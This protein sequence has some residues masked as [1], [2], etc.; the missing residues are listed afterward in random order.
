MMDLQEIID[1]IFDGKFETA[2]T[3][4][5]ALSMPEE[6]HPLL[7]M[8]LDTI[9][10]IIQSQM[11]ESSPALLA[12]IRP[13]TDIDWPELKETTLALS[14]I[15]NAGVAA[16]LNRDFEL[17][18]VFFDLSLQEAGRNMSKAPA[19]L[20][21]RAFYHLALTNRTLG[22]LKEGATQAE[23]ASQ[24]SSRTFT[25][26]SPNHP[27]ALDAIE[28]NRH[29]GNVKEKQ[30]PFWFEVVMAQMKLFP[31]GSANSN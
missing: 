1:S 5:R 6:T 26:I 13:W 3:D 29:Y 11:K 2:L 8:Y 25:R 22:N 30:F 12:K 24:I 19:R 20:L 10:L 14:V 16:A 7:F 28:L 17:A 27:E 18:R 31:Q 15:H 9:E 23:I 21:N 4:L